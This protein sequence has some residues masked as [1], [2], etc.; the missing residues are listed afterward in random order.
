MDS[1]HDLGGIEG[2]GPVARDEPSW[3]DAWER[4]VFGMTTTA[5]ITGNIDDFR[6]SIERLHPTIYLGASYFGR[7]LAGLEV[8]C[9]ERGLISSDEVDARSEAGR[10]ARPVAVPSL[11]LPTVSSSTLRTNSW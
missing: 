5:N 11:G 1:I 6:H 10:A 8:R 2:F 4:R 9:V 3:H 7:W